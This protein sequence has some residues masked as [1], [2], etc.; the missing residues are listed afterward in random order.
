[1]KKLTEKQFYRL[2]SLNMS[3][4][5]AL[6]EYQYP[7]DMVYSRQYGVFYTPPGYHTAALCLLLAFEKGLLFYQD[8]LRDLSLVD[9][10]EGADFFM[11]NYEGIVFKSSMSS[12]FCAWN[13]KSLNFQERRFFKEIIYLDESD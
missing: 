9:S 4:P 10:S 5:V 3:D 8:V 13:R 12:M 11:K 2:C 1:M 6:N 7:R